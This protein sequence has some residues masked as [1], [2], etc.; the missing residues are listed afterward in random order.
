MNGKEKIMKIKIFFSKASKLKEIE[1][2]NTMNKKIKK[3]ERK[4]EG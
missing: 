4:R 3:V 2:S 1:C